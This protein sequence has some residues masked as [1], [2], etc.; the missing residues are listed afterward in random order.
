MAQRN[1]SEM[2]QR[3]Q[4]RML[5]RVASGVAGIIAIAAIWA[6]AA[7]AG[8]PTPGPARG[9]PASN[10]VGVVVVSSQEKSDVLSKIAAGYDATHPTLDGQC[11]D[12]RVNTL[13]SGS[14]EAD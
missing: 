14:A 11:I 3:K 6:A 9:A 12:V 8:G 10:C 2:V 13:A 7:H 5:S 4:S 1:E